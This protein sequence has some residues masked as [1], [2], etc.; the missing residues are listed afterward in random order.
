MPKYYQ[1][2]AKLAGWASVER[3]CFSC[4]KSWTEKINICGEGASGL[5]S[6]RPGGKQVNQ[7]RNS[8]YHNLKK[9]EKRIKEQY[10]KGVLCPSCNHFCTGA[11]AKHFPRGF[12]AGVNKKFNKAVSSSL[13]STIFLSPFVILLGGVVL[14][15]GWGHTADEFWMRFLVGIIELFLLV[16]FLYNLILGIRIILGFFRVKRLL[17]AKNEDELLDIAVT[18]YRKNKNSLSGLYIWADMLLKCSKQN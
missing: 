2:T 5:T 18:H 10:D 16:L 11:M 7:A 9:E 1:A 13:L 8:A 15:G 17:R 14:S 3:E 6:G 12:R 4:K